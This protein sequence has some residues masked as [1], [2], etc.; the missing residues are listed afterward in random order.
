[1]LKIHY[2]IKKRLDKGK[3]YTPANERIKALRNSTN[4]ST[5]L[6]KCELISVPKPYSEKEKEI[7]GWLVEARIELSYK[8][9]DN[10]FKEVFERHTGIAFSPLD[11]SDFGTPSSALA[12]AQTLALSRALGHAGIGIDESIAGKE[13]IPSLEYQ[14]SNKTS[15]DTVNL[16]DTKLNKVIEETRE[17]D[18][19]FTD[20]FV[21][22]KASILEGIKKMESKEVW[23]NLENVSPEY[24]KDEML[25]IIRKTK[26]AGEKL[27]TAFYLHGNNGLLNT[28]K[29]MGY[30]EKYPESK[31]AKAIIEQDKVI[32]TKA[33]DILTKETSNDVSTL[34]L[35]ENAI[36]HKKD[37]GKY[38]NQCIIFIVAKDDN[39]A[40]IKTGTKLFPEID[41][42]KFVVVEKIMDKTNYKFICEGNNAAF[43]SYIKG[44]TLYL[45]SQASIIKSSSEQI[46]FERMVIIQK[47]NID[48]EILE[49]AVKSSFPIYNN[50]LDLIKNAPEDVF[51]NYLKIL[52]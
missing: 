17:L 28:A 52:K 50:I 25:N 2:D 35:S 13:E 41:N 6:D 29:Y 37:Y 3:E 18:V 42:E 15:I 10:G 1:M 23:F 34:T 7:K 51:E 24:F 22:P 9:T 14:S 48:S 19:T 40:L 27:Y 30:V 21:K 26:P 44:S 8:D 47:L 39:S 11:G 12:S 43:F 20:A 49:D 31:I 16:L 32:S 46:S 5:F 45:N 36:L 4:Y 38:K 33:I